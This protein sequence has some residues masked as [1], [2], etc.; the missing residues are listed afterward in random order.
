MSV[1]FTVAGE[2]GTTSF[3]GPAHAIKM[4]TAACAPGPR[5]VRELLDNARHYD[6]DFVEAVRNGLDRFDEHNTRADTTEI[7]RQ[8]AEKP[9]NELPPFRVLGEAT[10][11]AASQPGRIGLIIFNLKERRIVQVQN[12][13]AEIQRED[14]GR[15]RRL[16]H[17]IRALYHYRLPGDW[18]LVP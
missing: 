10:H 8:I 16:G 7:D 9:S 3:I 13:Y 17:P 6:A 14:R 11:R 12:S 15:I 4:L 18:A 1:R 2:E 5:T